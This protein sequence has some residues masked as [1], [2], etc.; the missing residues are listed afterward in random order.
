M[1]DRHKE[2]G[3]A[4]K[5]KQACLDMRISDSCVFAVCNKWGE[6]QIEGR[7]QRESEAQHLR[8]LAAAG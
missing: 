6:E 8:P 4:T 7:L 1:V 3:L 5:I 2:E